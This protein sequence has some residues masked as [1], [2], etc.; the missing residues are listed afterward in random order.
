MASHL[1]GTCP[2]DRVPN[3]GSFRRDRRTP[4]AEEQ[5]D[6]EE[7]NEFYGKTM[8]EN[9]SWVFTVADTAACEAS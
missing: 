4:Q 3:H 9:K 8:Q 2:T 7:F 1:G 5:L 6:A